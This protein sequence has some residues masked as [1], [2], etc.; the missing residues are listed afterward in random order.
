MNLPLFILR[1][2]DDLTHLFQRDGFVHPKHKHEP[3][4]TVQMARR[5]QEVLDVTLKSVGFTLDGELRWTRPHTSIGLDVFSAQLITKHAPEF[6]RVSLHVGFRVPAIEQAVTTTCGQ[7]LED[8]KPLDHGFSGTL[9]VRAYDDPHRPKRRSPIPLSYTLWN[10]DFR[11][12]VVEQIVSATTRYALPYFEKVKTV[13]DLKKVG[14]ATENRAALLVL[15]G[16]EEAALRLLDEELQ[17]TRRYGPEMRARLERLR[18]SIIARE[19]QK[20]LVK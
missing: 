12:S 3:M 15:L 13:G 5:L 16:D 17:K 10:V 1:R 2:W 14:M 8:G 7:W 11:D 20:E 6:L 9:L 19:L 18:E 4:T